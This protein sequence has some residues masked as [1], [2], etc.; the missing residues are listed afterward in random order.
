MRRR[1]DS[2]AAR[3]AVHDAVLVLTLIYGSETWILQKKNERKMNT[4]EMRSRRRI[5]EV[6]LDRI[7]NG[8]K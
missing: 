5:C 6:S 3:L 7:R 8:D 1:N 4:V 2:T